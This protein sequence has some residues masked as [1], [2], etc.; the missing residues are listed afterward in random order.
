MTEAGSWR[1]RNKRQQRR[2][3]KVRKAED[4]DVNVGRNKMYG[5]VLRREGV[6]VNNVRL[7][8]HKAKTASVKWRDG[9]DEV[10]EFTK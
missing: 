1:E 2:S 5:N 8:L 3:S 6:R 7:L 4:S 9:A 10:S